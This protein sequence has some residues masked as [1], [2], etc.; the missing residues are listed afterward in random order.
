M[1][2]KRETKLLTLWIVGACLLQTVSL[3]AGQTGD[4]AITRISHSLIFLPSLD[5]D[6]NRVDGIIDASFFIPP[7]GEVPQDAA[8]RFNLEAENGTRYPLLVSIPGQYQEG[9]T[10]HIRGVNP[11]VGVQRDVSLRIPR[12]LV[13]QLRGRYDTPVSFK[14]YGMLLTPFE[15]EQH[16]VD[17]SIMDLLPRYK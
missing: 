8:V 10:L 16:L 2:K 12:E 15:K 13:E 3:S 7:L 5:S 4:L 17:I 14:V 1:S 11:S 9:D 6:P